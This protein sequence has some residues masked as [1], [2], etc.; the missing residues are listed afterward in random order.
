M[1]ITTVDGLVAAATQRN[2]PLVKTASRTSTAAGFFS[3]FD[4]AG[5]PGAGTLNVGN[6]ANGL[7]PTD[8]TAGYPTINAFGGG[9]AGL[10]SR[11]SAYGSVPGNL[12]IYD[13]LFVCGAYAFNANTTGQTP[14]SFSSRV[15]GG[16]DFTDTQIWLEQVTAGTGVQNVAVTYLDQGNVSSTTGT[17][18]A[19]AAMIVGRC[20]QLPLA[21]GDT[22]VQG[23]TGVVGSVATAGT[24]NI[25]V[26][27][28]IWSGRVKIAN[29]GDVHDY[30]KTGMPIIYADS[31]LMMLVAPD[32]TATGIPELELV[33][34]NG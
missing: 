19:P 31:A 4:L 1:T 9:A 3:V 30:A 23:V 22:G 33:I 16:T 13:R 21:A 7:V 27:R 17:V 24:F 28:P 6:T 2:V 18:A 32:S 5:S 10:I 12:L 29:D 26:V 8:A 25:L 11:F 15:P 20:F 14:T 34:A